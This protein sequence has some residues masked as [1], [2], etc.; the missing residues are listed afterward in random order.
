MQRSKKDAYEILGVK[1]DSSPA[2]IKKAY[3]AVCM[4]LERTLII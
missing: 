3:Y 2:D 1:K 4:M